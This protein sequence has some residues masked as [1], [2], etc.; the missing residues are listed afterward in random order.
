MSHAARG[1]DTA[2]NSIFSAE[3]ESADGFNLIFWTILLS[4]IHNNYTENSYV[5]SSGILNM[6]AT[7][8]SDG[9]A[10]RDSSRRVIQHNLLQTL[11]FTFVANNQKLN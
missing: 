5:A 11:D 8:N 4:H 3:A 7:A 2:E 10:L 6:T 9:K 1:G